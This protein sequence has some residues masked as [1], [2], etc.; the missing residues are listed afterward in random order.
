VAWQWAEQQQART[1]NLR[2]QRQLQDSRSEL[3]SIQ[4]EIDRLNLRAARLDS[5]SASA[6]DAAQ[7]SLEEA[8]K[9]EAWK[10]RLR[11]LLMADDYRWPEDSPF[12][13]IPKKVVG[14]LGVNH[15]VVIPGVLKPEARELLGLTPPEREQIEAAL[16]THLAA[17]DRLVEDHLYETNRDSNF[18]I[19]ASA[20][21]SHVWAVPPLEDEVKASGA[22]L[23]A[24]L[25]ATLGPERW[26]LVK[27]Q[28]ASVDTLRR[29][30]NLDA[31]EKGQEIGAWVSQTGDN[32]TVGY[33]WSEKDSSFSNNGMALSL[34]TPGAPTDHGQN[35]V[36]SLEYRSLPAA[37]TARML[38]W[39]RQQAATRL[40]ETPK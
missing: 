5:A 35:P 10:T 4:T 13:R 6:A 38:E 30:L 17:M 23:E 40:G 27:E 39:I 18:S 8:R 24:A 32:L 14:Q 19:P 26:P 29:I 1:Q 31:G 36:E 20:L 2:V 16:Q 34:F 3:S 37:L 21:A 15:P 22:Q 9:F 7:K 12:V 28:L 11:A 25:Q 33:G